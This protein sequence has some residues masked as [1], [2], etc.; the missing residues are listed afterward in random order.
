VWNDECAQ[1]MCEM[2]CKNLRAQH[3][4]AEDGLHHHDLYLSQ[5]TRLFVS[6]FFLALSILP[7]GVA[8]FTF[9]L[10]IILS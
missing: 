9:R 8:A 6:F 4:P 10:L 7:C 5:L 1:F 2:M 3:Q